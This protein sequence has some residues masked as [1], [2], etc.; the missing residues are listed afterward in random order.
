[1][2]L[3]IAFYSDTYL[4]AVDGVVMS[5]LNLKKELERRGTAG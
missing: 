5:I 3:K 1:M 4:P 2:Q